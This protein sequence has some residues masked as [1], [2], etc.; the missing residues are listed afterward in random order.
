MSGKTE[1]KKSIK[2]SWTDSLATRISKSIVFKCALGVIFFVVLFS[3]MIL[4]VGDSIFSKAILEQ[5]SNDAFWTANM[6]KICIQ[7]SMM[8]YYME[9]NGDNFNH[10]NVEDL[11]NQV[12]NITG[13]TFIYVIQ[14]DRTDYGHITFLFSIMREGSPYQHYETG[15]VRE[16]TN[17]EYRDKYRQLYER[18]ADKAVV[19]RNTGII[20]TDPHITVMVPLVD[21]YTDE[22]T[23]ILCVQVQLE[24][25]NTVRYSYILSVF[26]V[27]VVLTI[28][29]IVSEV[30]YLNKL[31]LNPVKSI[32]AEASRFAKEG[33]NPGSKLTDG[34]KNKDE[35]G[36]LAE[37]IDTME[38][39]IHDYVEHLTKITAEKEKISTELS[40]AARIQN[41]ALPDSESSFKDRTDFTIAADMTPAKDIGGDFFDF[42]LIDDDH[43][44]LTIADVSGKGIP[45][46]LMMMSSKSILAHNAFKSTSPAEI[47][48]ISNNEICE[49]NEDGMFVTAWVGILELSTG[50]L[51]F[52]NAGHEH[53]IFKLKGKDYDVIDYKHGL[54]LGAIRDITHEDHEVVLKPGSQL[55]LYTDGVPEATDAKMEMFGMDRLVKTLNAHKDDAPEQVLKNVR[56]AVDA[57]V[58][59]AEQFDDL[60]MLCIDF[61]GKKKAKA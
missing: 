33:V 17:D 15:Y 29:M 21:P 18:T 44:Y 40:L 2:T 48:Q 52:A 51:V 26:L 22:T 47:L 49:R 38:D 27:L 11:L 4:F 32:T 59:E 31:I 23:A 61:Y 19:V 5:Y 3:V 1:E 12:C 53:P 30:L 50:K 41:H 54:V 39:K 6:A 43:L 46:A 20:E 57:F 9:N 8:S 60:T 16:T 10:K 42:F 37:S 14:P 34:I 25:L 56:S 55:F 24:A 36:L 58:K 7:P 45:A 13:V 28:M 35:I